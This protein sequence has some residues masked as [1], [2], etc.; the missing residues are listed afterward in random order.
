LK[1]AAWLGALLAAL[2]GWAYWPTLQEI[3][4]HWNSSPDYSHGY[5]VIPLAAW[6]LW[7]RRVTCPV[8]SIAPSWGGLIL[9]GL[10]AAARI[11]SARMYLPEVDGWSIPLWLGGA[12]WLCGG[13]SLLRWAAPSLAFLWFMVPLPATVETLLSRP[14]QLT[15]T[16]LSTWTLECLGQPALAEGTTILLNE[17][18]LEV[19]RACSGLRMFYGIFAL[20]VAYIMVVR[21]PRRTALVM[22]ASVAPIAL[23]ANM[24]RI[25]VTGLL[26]QWTTGDIARRFSHDFA[27]LLM[28]VLAVAMFSLVSLILARID[29]RLHQSRSRTMLAVA[30]YLVLLVVLVPAAYLW[31]E[32]QQ[33]RNVA[34]FLSRAGALEERGDWAQAAE[35]LDRYLRLQP[36]SPEVRARLARTFDKA[37]VGTI[38]QARALD[39]YREAWEALPEDLDLAK[40]HAELA[41]ELGQYDDARQTAEALLAQTADNPAAAAD[42][43]YAARLNALAMIGRL[44]RQQNLGDQAQWLAVVASL[45]AALELN[46][47]DVELA[48][49]LAEIHRVRLNEPAEEERA[50]TADAVLDALV[51]ANPELP[52][53]H[54]ARY[55]YLRRYRS[56]NAAPEELA[57]IDADLDR[58]LELG[59]QDPQRENLEVLLTAGEREIV[60]NQ[61]DEARKLFRRATEL[62]PLDHRAWLRLGELELAGDSQ[63]SR[64]RAVAVWREGLKA[65]GR[66]EVTL[67]V[68]L[69]GVL[70]DLGRI[71]EAEEL[72]RPL[73]DAIPFLVEPGR[74]ALQIGVTMLR[75][76][77]KAAV[78]RHGEA[79]S[80]LRDLV[81]AE[82]GYEAAQQLRPQFANAWRTLGEYYTIL[83]SADQAAH[84]FEQAGRLDPSTPEWHWK[85]ARACEQAGRLADAVQ[86]LESSARQNSSD[87]AVWLALARVSLIHQVELPPEDRDWQT[88]RR[89]VERAATL[90]GNTP[91]LAIF[92]ADYAM[93]EERTA[94]AVAQL[95]GALAQLPDSADLWRAMTVVRHRTKNAAETE[96]ALKEFERVSK[97][98]TAGVLLRAGILASDGKTDAARGVLEAAL[99]TLADDKKFDVQ[100]EIAQL[101]LQAGRLDEGRQRLQ[102]LAEAHPTDVGLLELLARL[103]LE[104]RD[105]KGL[106]QIEQGLQRIEGNDGSVWRDFRARRLLAQAVDVEDDR[107]REAVRLVNEMDKLRP[108][109]HRTA[110]LRGQIARREGRP[111]DAT[112]A[113]EMAVQL[114]N[115]SISLAEELIDLLTE[116]RRFAEADRQLNRVRDSVSRSS[117]LSTV[118]IPIYVRRGE[119]DE[120]LRLAEDWVRR[121][122]NDPASHM[123]LART[124]LITAGE[125]TTAADSLDRAERSFRRAVELDPTDVRTWVGLFHFYVRYRQNETAAL[126]TLDELA[127]RVD[128][129]PARQSFV[130]AQ[131]YESVGRTAQ[132]SRYY[133]EAVERAPEGARVQVWERA[134][135]FFVPIDP[136]FA[137][138]LSR[139]ALSASPGSLEA[140]RILVLALVEQGGDKRL[141]E[142]TD[143]FAAVETGG[144]QSPADRRLQAALLVRRGREEDRRNAISILE[145]LVQIPQQAQ[146][147]DR[148]QL[149][150]LY[151]AE[152]RVQPAYEQLWAVAREEDASP[153][154]LAAFVE[155]LQRNAEEQPQFTS[156]AESILERLESQPTSAVSALRLRIKGV[157]KT[158]EG[159]P[160]PEGVR[161]IVAGYLQ[162]QVE[163]AASDA[164]R[165]EAFTNLLMLLVR[166]DLGDEALRV[167]REAPPL[168]PAQTAASLASALTVM[169]P[170]PQL[171]EKVEPYL[172]GA[173]KEA[174]GD[175]DLLFALANLRYVNERRDEAVELYRR[176]LEA[177]PAHKLA[178]NNLA[179]SLSDDPARIDEALALITRSIESTGRDPGLLDTQAVILI[180]HQQPE[181]ARKIL[182][183]AAKSNQSEPLYLLHLAAAYR[184][185]G[186]AEMARRTYQRAIELD[187]PSAVIT[188]G[189]HRLLKDLEQAFGVQQPGKLEQ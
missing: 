96:R 82:V 54:L 53:A 115:R 146:P 73:E 113:Y 139:R 45:N 137:E 124:L 83:E 5:L 88:F 171:I 154:H 168:A 46:P 118:A 136:A 189:D 150:S 134:A 2:F 65:V 132:A 181:Q 108:A 156:R 99:P 61:A 149:A 18:V 39:L 117:R 67:I 98:S 145:G 133:R 25:V 77:A 52:A 138:E 177:R 80:L 97:D 58:A 31:H 120:A 185:E 63:E 126:S 35:Y 64:E 6:F 163:G 23:I 167:C 111:A 12:V 37:A 34:A 101:D 103:A 155:F 38:H 41:M 173:L 70:I 90:G 153:I 55:R 130:L 159:T 19:E 131:L 128:I 43:A 106:E 30:G 68:P 17:N 148:V 121:Q 51:T 66:Q 176:T 26:F 33:G 4:S 16:R 102:E 166:E 47:A 116:Q 95:E 100:F 143:L 178:V 140:R 71:P 28:I 109:W 85:A 183:E 79:V 87:P 50:K 160:D 135:Q 114:G 8:S 57:R 44:A 48:V 22:L 180:K 127:G 59:R 84:A 172:A 60:R 174:P 7:A 110:A 40:R 32:F 94:D 162:H 10:A 42:H 21:A 86:L 11:I 152:N 13:W 188:P 92:Q 129:L 170:S 49:R 104:R 187:A 165:V 147:R 151:E 107:F 164:L 1:G 14:L 36:D 169:R 144:R 20:S 75:A 29:R 81:N 72:L 179:L 27:G 91:L 123:R 182:E 122:P 125:G 161:S 76:R 56:E 105:W 158:P 74:T 89:A 78:Q 62:Q 157:Q 175:A 186:N 9:L 142:A 24:A 93:A 15:A 119:T 3:V 141:A 112:A 69:T 184:G